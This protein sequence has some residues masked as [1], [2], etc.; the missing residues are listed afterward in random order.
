MTFDTVIQLLYV[1]VEYYDNEGNLRE[2][3]KHFVVP[4]GYHFWQVVDST[5]E[6]GYTCKASFQPPPPPSNAYTI[7]AIKDAY[8]QAQ[9]WISTRLVEHRT[10][11]ITLELDTSELVESPVRLRARYVS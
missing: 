3:K 11:V 6:L 7:S 4:Y 8:F 10:N 1:T 9:N 2:T 5:L